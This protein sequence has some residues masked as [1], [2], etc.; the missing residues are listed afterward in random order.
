MSSDPHGLARASLNEILDW[1]KRGVQT[2]LEW[3]IKTSEVEHC[4]TMLKSASRARLHSMVVP[5]IPH[6][7]AMLQAM[8]SRRR[9]RAF[10]AGVT[11]LERL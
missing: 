9:R 4:L 3:T 6:L 10:E 7:E 5:A 8:R 11:A 2:D 1:L